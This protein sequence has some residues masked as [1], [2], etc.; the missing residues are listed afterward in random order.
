VKNKSKQNKT[1]KQTNKQKNAWYW[2]RDREVHQ[3]NR[4]E[5][6]ETYPHPY[7]HLIFDK[8]KKC[9]GKKKASSTNGANLTG[10]LCVEECKLVQIYVL[11]KAQI[12][13]NQRHLHKTTYTETYRRGSGK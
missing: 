12:Q 4:I 1:S 6:P 9:S 11:Y 10:G 7:G 3:W 8:P 13:V 2:Y 5:D